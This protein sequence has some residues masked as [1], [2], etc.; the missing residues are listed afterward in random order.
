LS[1]DGRVTDRRFVVVSGKGGVGRT[2]VTAALAR[3]AA[4][5]GKRVLVAQMNAHERLGA[6]FGRPGPI[7]P[8]VVS[9]APGIDAVN[10]TPRTALHEYGVM[11]LKLEA[12]YRAV[13]ENRAVRGFLSAVPG[14]DAYA[15]L[16]K[17]WFHT[18][19]QDGRRPRHDLVLVD[20]PASGH[21][22]PMLKIPSAILEAVPKGPLT[23][24][25]RAIGELIADPARAAFVVVT[26]PEEL[27]ARES[28]TLIRS[29][30]GELGMAVGPL[31]VNGVPP[32]ALDDPALVAVLERTEAATG[33]AALDA[34]IAAIRAAAARRRDADEIL[35]RLRTDPGLPM[36]ELPRVAKAQ[37]D[38]EDVERMADA[39]GAL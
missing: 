5:R 17:A 10:M 22:V 1:L 14:L 9:V 4:R 12:L 8:E 32:A 24:D 13:F 7:G 30:R 16:G 6:L 11:V 38:P 37:L 29:V 20:G 31:V 27:P 36:V 35:E 21:V 2:T 34:T 25:A 3:V 18:T 19:V 28:S 33:D 39:L 15:M 23:K 26:L